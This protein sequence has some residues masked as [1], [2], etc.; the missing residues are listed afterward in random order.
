MGKHIMYKI[1]YKIQKD[2]QLKIEK[3]AQNDLYA[4]NIRNDAQLKINL[5]KKIIEI[6]VQNDLYDDADIVLS[7]M[8]QNNLYT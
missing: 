7:K 2:E 3:L 1:I 5:Y 8:V 4:N 6:L